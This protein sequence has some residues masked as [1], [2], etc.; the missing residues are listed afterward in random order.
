MQPGIAPLFKTRAFADTLLTWAGSTTSYAD[1][2]KGYWMG[3]LGSQAAFDQALQ[4]G[5]IEPGG[6]LAGQTVSTM[7]AATGKWD[8]A[9]VTPAV[10]AQMHPMQM[11]GATFSGNTA[12]ATAAIAGM[13]PG[14]GR[15]LVVYEKV[16]IGRGGCWS[17]N[18][19]LLELPDPITKATWDNYA[20]ISPVMAKALDAGNQEL[21]LTSQNEVVTAK[22]VI[23]VT[24]NGKSI[25][26]PAVIVPGM[27]PDVI[28]IA[29]GYGRIE[30]VGRAAANLGKNAYPFLVWNGQT[31]ETSSAG[32]S[33]EKTAA[34]YDIAIT[35][36]HQSYEGRAIIHEYAL[37][38]FQK[39][40]KHLMEEREEE[41]GHF[42]FLP[43]VG[44]DEQNEG[45]GSDH[46]NEAAQ[47][48]HERF[49]QGFRENGTSYPDY[50][51]LGIHWGM[52]VDLNSCIGCGACVIGCQAENNVSVVGKAK[53]LK[54]QEMHWITIDRYFAGNPDNADSIQTV[55]Q[56]MMCQHCDNAPCE[57]CARY[58]LPTTAPKA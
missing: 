1:M 29:V 39:N 24:V 4:D 40:P 9:A 17:N 3:K 28:A 11:S 41:L 49:E 42:A 51:H 18:P 10:A 57:M 12:A 54:S 48:E 20:C 34:K 27:H 22:R 21:E 23:K 8:T 38:D 16:G 46:S 7:D 32:A 30:S 45:K 25:E 43:W 37:A 5:V 36:T 50:K 6:S 35:Q 19:W 47:E 33:V 2:W 53:V 26:L 31:F 52:S 58:Q 55:F 14:S 56:P 15:E 44:H 13:K